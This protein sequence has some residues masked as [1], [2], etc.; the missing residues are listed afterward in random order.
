MLF[1]EYDLANLCLIAIFAVIINLALAAPK[2]LYKPFLHI[3]PDIWWRKFITVITKKLNRPHRAKQVRIKRGALVTVI[4]ALILLA[5]GF[6]MNSIFLY[7]YGEYVEIIA[8]ALTLSLR[9]TL[10]VS[11]I[12]NSLIINNKGKNIKAENI[13]NNIL[14]SQR[15]EYDKATITRYMIEYLALTTNHGMLAPIFYYLLFGWPVVLLN[16]GIG[17]MVG[18]TTKSNNYQR[19]YFGKLALLVYEILQ[20]LPSRITGI[21]LIISAIFSPA[22]NPVTAWRVMFEQAD[23]LQSANDGWPIAAMAGA[24]N[25]TLGGP[26]VINGNHIDDNWIG[27]GSSQPTIA[28]LRKAVWLFSISILLLIIALLAITISS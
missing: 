14:R 20:W 1:S 15:Q 13:P 4:A 7:N 18:I 23:K 17:I 25:V 27:I 21:W 12:V 10:E 2:S 6:A 16:S 5:I 24:I 22:A 11:K 26:R 9:Q 19:E 8:L 28:E 3:A